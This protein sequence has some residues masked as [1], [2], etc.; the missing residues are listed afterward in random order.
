MGIDDYKRLPRTEVPG[1]MIQVLRYKISMA[2]MVDPISAF[3]SLTE[4]EK[5]NPRVE[6]VIDDILE[7]II[8]KN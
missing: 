6:G 7:E 4:K 5:S 8:K 1:C 2:D 3:L